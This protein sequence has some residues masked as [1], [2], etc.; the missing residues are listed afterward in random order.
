[1]SRR[2]EGSA[3]NELNINNRDLLVH[4]LEQ[5]QDQLEY[6]FIK[7][8]EVSKSYE[9]ASDTITAF[10]KKNKGLEARYSEL[11]ID[12]NWIQYWKAVY[13]NNTKKSLTKLIYHRIKY[14]LKKDETCQSPDEELLTLLNSDLFNS[15]W[16]LKEYPDLA[17]QKV[18]PASHFLNF[19]FKELRNPSK[20]FCTHKYLEKY[21]DVK[22]SNLNPLVHYIHYGREEGRRRF[23]V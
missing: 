19:G 6:Y 20:K 4:Q 12:F 1:M 22:E 14:L 2:F 23:S 17:E 13:L 16:Y 9:L 15:H 18:E 7:C 10:R 21:P 8:N 5:T 3:E 11:V